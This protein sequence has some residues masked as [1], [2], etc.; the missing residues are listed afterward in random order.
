MS[1]SLLLAAA[2]VLSAA[3]VWISRRWRVLGQAM[4]VLGGLGLIGVLALQVRQNVFAPEPKIPDRAEM[5]VSFCLANCLLGDLAGRGGSVVLLFP[6]RRLMDEDSERSFE[7]GFTPPLRHGGGKLHVKALHLE[8]GD[9][10]AEPDV[11]AFKQALAQV[12]EALAI[13]SYAGVPAGFETLF[14]EGHANLAALY[15]FDPQGTTNWLGPLKNGRVRA[16]VVPRP[17]VEHRGPGAL[18]GRPE[19]IFERCY[20]LATPANAEQV[21]ASLKARN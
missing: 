18:A 7:D 8:A 4:M 17:G 13:V 12:P 15:V 14:S 20:L 19:T 21:A 6:S 9:R 16:V 1:L 5:A 10:G 3:G 11:S 2:L